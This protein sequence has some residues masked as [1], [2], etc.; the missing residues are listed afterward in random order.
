MPILDSSDYQPNWLHRNGHLSTMI[1]YFFQKKY[2]VEFR[3]TRINTPDSD[4]LDIDISETG[5]KKLAVLN[6][7]LEGS[8]QSRYIVSTRNLMLKDGWDVLAWNYRGCS[9]EMNRNLRMYHSGA[10]DDLHHVIEQFLGNYDEIVVVG[11]SLGGNL[12]L[13]YLGEGVFTPSD[14]IKAVVAISVPCDL[15][16]CGKALERRENFLYVKRFLISLSKKIK[17]K[18]RLYPK[19]IKTKYLKHIRNLKEF[20]DCYTAP[21]HGFIDAEDYYQQCSSLQ[22]ISNIDVPSLI[23]NAKDDPFLHTK[24]FPIKISKSSETIHLLAPVYGGHVGFKGWNK[25]LSW[26]E[27]KSLEF[28]NIYTD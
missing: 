20:D 21:L 12:A 22:Y 8:S 28:A 25:D 6:H 11:F 3:R 15:S 13:K 26:A 14:K 24:A 17:E 1:P 23:I 4:F 18:S 9:G 7:G 2:D 5:S 16:A 10:T 19:E 27:V